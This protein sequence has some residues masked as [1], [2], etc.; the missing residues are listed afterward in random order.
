MENMPEAEVE[1]NADI[2]RALIISQ[3]PEFSGLDVR[4]LANGWDNVMFRLGDDYTV[5][6]PRRL[7]AVGL[8]VSE[9]RWLPLLANQLTMP[10]PAPVFNGQPSDGFPWPWSICKWMRGDI[11]ERST[12]DPET[13]AEQLGAFL[14]ALHQPAPDSAPVNEFR[15][16]PLKQRD[17]IFR[18]RVAGLPEDVGGIGSLALW[19]ELLA[20][21]P[22]QGPAVWLHG[23][24]HP[25]NMLVHEG[26]LSAVI[27]FG[28]ITSGDPATDL[29][30]A[31]MLFGRDV[32]EV[33][34]SAAGDVD[35]NTWRRARGWA[36]ALS[37]A[38]MAGSADNPLIFEIGKRTFDCVIAGD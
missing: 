29:A 21:P 38:Y 18:E 25:A 34:R 20:T 13:L 14:T 4:P 1:V 23:D 27:D 6:L 9:Q 28:D 11:A 15:G 37:V 24:L 8:L 36:L 5:R 12:F 35:D 33:F 2:V 7:A 30:V 22:W 31:W 3:A 16:V 10:I 17:A 32:R 19:D 26:R